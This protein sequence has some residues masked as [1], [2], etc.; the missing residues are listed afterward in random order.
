MTESLLSVDFP[1]TFAAIQDGIQR[2]LHTG[3]QIC[4][5]LEGRTRINTGVG[6]AAPDVPMSEHTTMLW[7]SA[8]KPL[9]AA[10]IC[11]F[12]E[13]GLLSIDAPIASCLPETIDSG[14]KTVTLRQLLTHESGLPVVES[15]WPMSGWNEIT[16][17]VLQLSPGPPSAAYQP[18]NTWFLLGEILQ[19]TDPQA[20][21]F[22]RILQDE[23]LRPAG[24]TE[25]IC[26]L[27]EDT[28]PV[29]IA[30]R[31]YLRDK[32]QLIES[33]F[34][35]SPWLTSPSPG[36]NFRGPVRQL[37]E[38]YELLRRAGRTCNDTIVLQEST[39][40]EMTAR[41]RKERFDET[42]RHIV[43][44]GLGLIVDSSRYGRATVPYGFGDHCSPAT[45][46]HGGAQ[47]AMGFCDP[48]HELVVAWAANG[49]CGEGMHQRRNRAI[50]EAVYEDLGLTAVAKM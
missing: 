4:V 34:H 30:P 24:I 36:G 26:G 22:D 16:E 32:G 28:L 20:R 1:R 17:R 21:S 42:F 12:A 3:V 7:R 9:T 31:F 15:G 38:F 13:R 39:V 27:Q 19:R 2:N 18:Q 45:F 46:G 29:R 37:A 23:L 14:L 8:G 49:F 35:K 47:C 41:H 33:R 43:D 6:F 40:T 5:M 50:N 44:F 11:L 10:A 25:A 48:N